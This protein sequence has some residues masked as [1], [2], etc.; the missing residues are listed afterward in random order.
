MPEEV[1][2]SSEVV[3]GA[4]EDPGALEEAAASGEAGPAAPGAEE[5][6]GE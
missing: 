5:G 3:E 4:A 1:F 2:Q 6:A